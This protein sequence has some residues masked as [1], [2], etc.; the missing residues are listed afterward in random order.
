MSYQ[1]EM[2]TH[3]QEISPGLVLDMQKDCRE[4][5]AVAG[6]RG[7]A[8]RQIEVC[9]MSRQ[10]SI[11]KQGES[12]RGPAEWEGKPVTCLPEGGHDVGDTAGQFWIGRS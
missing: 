10:T 12:C 8:C 5:R 1:D 11:V 4:I 7:V 9:M 2:V 3:N 6:A